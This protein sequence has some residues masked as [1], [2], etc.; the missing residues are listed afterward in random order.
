MSI[1]NTSDINLSA[2]VGSSSDTVATSD[3]GSFSVISLIKRGLQNWT[4]ILSR[5]PSLVSGRVPV[6][7]SGVTQPVST[8]MPASIIATQYK[9]TATATSVGSGVLSNGVII[10]AR[11]TNVGTVFIGSSSSLTTTSD[12]TGNG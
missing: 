6:D 9:V 10:K 7:G 4:T 8:P 12:G 5:I 3:T 1:S 11:S 2:S